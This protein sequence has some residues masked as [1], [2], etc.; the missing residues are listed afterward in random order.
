MTL[1]R[2]SSKSGKWDIYKNGTTVVNGGSN[3]ISIAKNIAAVLH[4]QDRD[5][6]PKF[7]NAKS[8]PDALLT[9]NVR[10]PESP[11]YIGGSG[12]SGKQLWTEVPMR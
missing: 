2:D 4:M 11:S 9:D 6:T 1:K 12:G 5:L 8:V 3:K 10:R 7:S